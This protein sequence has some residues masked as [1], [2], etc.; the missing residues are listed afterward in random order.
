MGHFLHW[1]FIV[2]PVSILV[3]NLIFLTVILCFIMCVTYFIY[4][5]ASH[6]LYS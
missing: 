3:R 2:V 5:P 4:N 1:T 6:S